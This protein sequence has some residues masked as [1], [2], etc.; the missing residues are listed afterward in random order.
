M[1]GRSMA[2]REALNLAISVRFAARQ[3]EFRGVVKVTVTSGKSHRIRLFP[4]QRRKVDC[5]LGQGQ[6]HWL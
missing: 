2:G 5:G 6:A 4:P 1:P 3:P